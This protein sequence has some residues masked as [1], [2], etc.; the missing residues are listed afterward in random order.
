MCCTLSPS[1]LMWVR[2]TDY[3]LLKESW[4]MHQ[5]SIYLWFK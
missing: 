5:G 1:S 4:T 2:C 3:L